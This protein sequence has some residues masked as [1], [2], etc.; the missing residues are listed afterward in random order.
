MVSALEIFRL[1][2]GAEA[3][4]LVIGGHD[5]PGPVEYI[6]PVVDDPVFLHRRGAGHKIHSVRSGK[7]AEDLLRPFPVFIGQLRQTGG[8]RGEESHV[9][10]FG[11]RQ[12]IR[13]IPERVL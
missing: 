1:S 11:E 10:R 4:D 3:V 9:H 5:I 12:N 13:R 2:R 8:R 7:A 6:G